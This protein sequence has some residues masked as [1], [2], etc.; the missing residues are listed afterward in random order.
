MKFDYGRR[1]FE[2]FEKGFERALYIGVVQF[3]SKDPE[4][5][6]FITVEDS[7]LSFNDGIAESPTSVVTMDEGAIQN[8][9]VMAT[10]YDPR[11]VEFS[12]TI[13]MTGNKKLANFLCNL[14][15]RPTQKTLK[16]LALVK[17]VTLSGARFSEIPKLHQPKSQD[18]LEH[19]G[20]YTPL[21]MTGIL[22]E[23]EVFK[24]TAKSLEAHFG[25]YQ[26]VSYLPWTIR[27]YTE[28]EAANYSG[29]TGLTGVLA[30]K[31]RTPKVLRDTA[32]IGFPQLWLGASPQAKK[33]SVT[34][35]HCDCVHGVLCQIYGRKKIVF[36]PPYEE[37]YLYPYRAFNRYRSCWTG[38][39]AVDYERYPLFKNANPIE[40]IINPGEAILIPFGWY[41]CVYALDPLMSISYPLESVKY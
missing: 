37:E 34:S 40:V 6:F 30:S 39:D 38:P 28:E 5:K 1:L 29:G 24:W 32:N 23:W 36:Y 25:N 14:V 16:E 26:V 19:M 18:L 2:E 31:F 12:S 22:D 3:I 11:V 7:S 21:M 20:T 41:H 4:Q 13:T 17:E 33:K 10:T 15:M 35:L 27:N 8:M 9:V